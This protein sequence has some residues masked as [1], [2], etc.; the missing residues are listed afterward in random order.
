MVNEWSRQKYLQSQGVPNINDIISTAQQ[1]ADPRTKALFIITYW[2]AGR[3]GEIVRKKD[4]D[5]NQLNSIK[6]KDLVFMDINNRPSILIN[7]RNQKNRKKHIKDIPIMLD[8]RENQE[9][10]AELTP[11]LNKLELEDELFPFAY[12]YAYKLLT[13]VFSNPHWIRHVRLTHLVVLYDFSEHFLKRYAGWTDTR[14][15]QHYVELRWTD[16]ADKL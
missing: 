3:I 7:I 8:R 1:I 16:L 13:R 14:P 15:G 9:L 11:Y 4:K 2:T 10:L 6:K 5:D 12:T